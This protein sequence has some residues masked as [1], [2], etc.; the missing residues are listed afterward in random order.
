MGR[1]RGLTGDVAVHQGSVRFA[2]NVLPQRLADHNVPHAV[3]EN[4]HAAEY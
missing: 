3:S 4:P 1:H 2:L